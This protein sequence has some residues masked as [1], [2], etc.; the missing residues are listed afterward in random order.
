[1][2]ACHAFDVKIYPRIEEAIKFKY[3]V[4]TLG[5]MLEVDGVRGDRG[6]VWPL[7]KVAVENSNLQ[8]LEF[9]MNKYE[10]PS[11]G[12]QGYRDEVLSVFKEAIVRSN[13]KAL[14]LL[15]D[16]IRNPE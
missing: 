6:E 12:F 9:I 2:A 15:T 10:A 5:M 3:P 16:Y 1:M 13:L 11:E 8:A 14:E 7:L 4:G